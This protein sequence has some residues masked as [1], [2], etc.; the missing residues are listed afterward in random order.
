VNIP[1]RVSVPQ[2]NPSSFR[3]PRTY[4]T[5]QRYPQT[6]S[7]RVTQRVLTPGGTI[8]KSNTQG[9]ATR[10]TGGGQSHNHPFTGSAISFSAAL[11]PLRVQYIDVITCSLD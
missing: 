5:P 6:T 4:R 11:S 10:S 1:F 2:R 8:R 9:P 3:Q 7:V